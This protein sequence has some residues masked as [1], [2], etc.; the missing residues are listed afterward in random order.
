MHACLLEHVR[1][2]C[3]DKKHHEKNK[4]VKWQYIHIFLKLSG[5]VDIQQ[6]IL[7]IISMVLLY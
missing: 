5:T 4:S 7:E 1:V 3:Q 2:S 6:I